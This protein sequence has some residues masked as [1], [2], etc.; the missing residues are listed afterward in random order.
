MVPRGYLRDISPKFPIC[1]EFI[2]GVL[3]QPLLTSLLMRE[4]LS[5]THALGILL[6]W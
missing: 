4:E 2:V 6:Q 3:R 1:S 5:V